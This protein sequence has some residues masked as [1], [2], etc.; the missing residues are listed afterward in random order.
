MS[1]QNKIKNIVVDMLQQSNEAMIKNIDRI[2]KSGSIDIEN[3]SEDN[4]PM[5]L[6]KS[7]IIALLQNESS[8]H[9]AEGTSFEKRIKKEVKNILN[10]I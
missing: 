3:W 5:I 7:I 8:Q 4:N 2:L 6:P 10:F 1:K 9:G